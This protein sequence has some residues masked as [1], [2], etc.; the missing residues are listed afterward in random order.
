MIGTERSEVAYGYGSLAHGT[1]ARIEPIMSRSKISQFTKR[2]LKK[3]RAHVRL[4]VFLVGAALLC[5][6]IWAVF[7]SQTLAY[8]FGKEQTCQRSPRLLPGLSRIERQGTFAVNRPNTLS[9]GRLPIYSGQ[10]CVSLQTVPK[11]KSAVTYQERLFGWSFLGRDIKVQLADFPKL[12]RKTVDLVALPPDGTLRL[13]LDKS[14]ITFGYLVRSGDHVAGCTVKQTALSCD[15]TS[16]QLKYA[17]KYD[18]EITR[19]FARKEI[20]KVAAMPIQTITPI[21][22]LSA[23][24]GVN[25]NVQQKPTDLTLQTDKDIA[26][27][28]AVTFV[29]KNGDGT[30]TPLLAMATFTVKTIVVKFG[31]ELP[32]RAKLELRIAS[33]KAADGSGLAEKTLTLPFSTSGGPKVTGASIGPRN[34]ALGQ[35]FTIT[36]DQEL[37]PG[38]DIG[39]QAVFLVQGKA[40]P[41]DFVVTGNKLQIKPKN[42]LPLCTPFTLTLRAGIQSAYTVSGDSAWTLN[43][44]TICYTTF[45]I[46]TSLRGRA[47]T[48]YKFGAGD[49]PIVYM[50]AMHGDEVNSKS[51]M[52]EWFNELTANPGR[53]PSRSLVVIPAVNPDGV[54]TRSRL[55]ARGIDL[56]RNFP[57]TDWKTM[58]TS[59]ESPN[60][61]PAGGPT[62]LSEPESSAIAAYIRQVRPRMVFSFHSSAAVVEANEA[63]DSVAVALTYASKARYRAVPKSQSASVFK[64]DT[65]G[66]M[67]DWL[68]TS[69]GSPAIVVEL[70]S[71]TSSEFSRNR[72]ALWFSA[73]L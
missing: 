64:Y 11:A 24:I 15:L 21:S 32:R 42:P 14:D 40:Q 22:I 8:D 66:A 18:L 7:T 63:G 48:A 9:I 23:S 38:Q 30:E 5:L 71:D 12:S 31:Q 60:P 10:I 59:P 72:D 51:I 27:L 26:A 47:I 36:F 68:R 67:E 54:A 37:L 65:T 50:G 43:S 56:N 49:N 1:I 19:T 25:A 13:A 73:G 70:L 6:F 16:L 4:C 52:T 35:A 29:V 61:T 44:R 45:S 69:L 62:P 55:N 39:A 3:L 17:E 46:G 20:S 57:A 2:V 41:A 58:V 34:V 33:I 53:M 28:G